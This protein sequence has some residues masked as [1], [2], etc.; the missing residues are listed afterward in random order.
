MFN[1]EPCMEAFVDIS[2]WWPTNEQG[3]ALSVYEVHRQLEGGPNQVTRHTLTIARDGR[4]YKADLINLVKLAR[5]CSDL[6][7]AEVKIDDFVVVQQE[8]D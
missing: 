8:E 3:K 4:M 6:S 7:G 5:I 2:R 1:S